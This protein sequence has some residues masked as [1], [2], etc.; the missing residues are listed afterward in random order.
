MKNKRNQIIITV[1][2][3][4]IAVAGYINY[5]GSLSD[6][7]SVKNKESIETSND[8]SS[9]AS[10]D[11][12][13]DISMESDSSVN[14]ED[15]EVPGTAILTSAQI[16]TAKLNREQIRAKNKESL[17]EIVNNNDISNEVK[18]EA[19]DKLTSMTD[20]SEKEVACELLLEA[21]GFKDS[22]VSIVDQKADVVINASSI[23]DAQ[24]AQIEDILKRKTGLSADKISINICNN[25]RYL[26]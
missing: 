5:T 18:Q 20:A 14:F 4:M 24:R 3:V 2:A 21:K 16:S 13:Y 7:I 12:V 19:V 10:G 8:I 26:L 6:I 9:N 1:L 11:E 22:I 17:M 25:W 15:G 23:T